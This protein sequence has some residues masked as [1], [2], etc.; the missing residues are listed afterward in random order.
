VLPKPCAAATT[1]L[2]GAMA[3]RIDKDALRVA[4]EEGPDPVLVVAADAGISQSYLYELIQREGWRLRRSARGRRIGSGASGAS[5]VAAPDASPQAPPTPLPAPQDVVE[6][7]GVAGGREP[8]GQAA[9]VRPRRSRKR[10]S[11][12]RPVDRADMLRRLMRLTARQIEE[13][14]TRLG[15][16]ERE[17]VDA[18]RDARLIGAVAKTLDVI[19]A[20]TRRHEA[21]DKQTGAAVDL[22]ALRKE[23]AERLEALR[24]AS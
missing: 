10:R 23:L 5:G 13:I 9:S 1:G 12:K 11:D 15:A 2:E 8:G 17:A 22:D 20:A 21:S 6:A 14:E 16:G 7:G 24:Q 4:Y 18:E 3:S 19:T